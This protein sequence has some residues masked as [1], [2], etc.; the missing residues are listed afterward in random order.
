VYVAEPTRHRVRAIDPDGRARPFA[1]TGEEGS[2]GDGEPA[3]EARLAV[4]VSVAVDSE[5]YVLIADQ[6]ERVIRR[7][8]PD[9]IIDTVAENVEAR[10]LAAG[11][12]GTVYLTAGELVYRLG[13]D[14]R[15]VPVAGGGERWAEKADGKPAAQA[16]LWETGAVAA[17]G[18]SVYFAEAGKPSVRAVAP[19]G[20]LV[21][22]AGNS[23]LSPEEGGFAGDGGPAVR[24]ELNHPTGLAVGPDGERYVADT[25]NN[26]IRRI[27]DAGV[28]TTVA[29]TGERADRGDGEPAT[30]AALTEPTSV[31]VG[32][33]G[34][35]YITSTTSSRVRRVD[36]DGT[37]DTLADLD[38]P[39]P[40]GKATATD[41]GTLRTLAVGVDGT[42]Y[43][44]TAAGLRTVA[45][46]GTLDPA[47]PGDAA[48]RT[49]SEVVPARDGSLLAL[50]GATLERY[51]PDGGVLHTPLG[52]PERAPT[53]D[54]AKQPELRHLAT[55]PRDEVY[56]GGTTAI[57]RVA[58]DGTLDQVYGRRGGDDL[59]AFTVGPDGSLFVLSGDQVLRLR[60]G[61]AEPVTAAE[62]T[63]RPAD[64]EDGGP[65]KEASLSLPGD[66]AVTED[67]TL[68][69]TTADGVRRVD[70]GGDID[71]VVPSTTNADDTIRSVTELAV[72][73]G[74]DLYL[75][76][77]EGK[78]DVL[79]RPGELPTSSGS[80]WLF[81]F[82]GVALVLAG[83][84]LTFVLRRR[85]AVRTA[86]APATA[87]ETSGEPAAEP[88][89]EPE[90]EK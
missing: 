25:Y 90:T 75:G 57:H 62:S 68:F 61:K 59:G 48:F 85:V 27:D 29:G 78:V 6:H 32:R 76:Y 38:P 21:T 22:V 17:D 10:Q 82:G 72:G 73:P 67:G 34:E 23:Y 84:A 60:D 89:G 26:R 53:D 13:A 55:G 88:A 14:G 77:A 20:V 52:G 18:G 70:T 63:Y 66:L 87:G 16:G 51:Y 69:V 43:L 49:S 36:P 64:E 9:G 83:A 74:G 47:M 58:E 41:L 65:A 1:G 3:E 39:R 71:T 54:P 2:D 37:I 45:R 50:S 15:P 11:T 12:N 30:K 80:A 81:W 35:L 44:D 5:G 86:G 40:D 56:V 4:P 46:D 79:V 24:A 28:I 31:A 19:N 42:L 7:V 8:D 33:D